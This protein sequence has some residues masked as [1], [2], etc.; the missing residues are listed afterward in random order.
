MRTPE[1]VESIER[2]LSNMSIDYKLIDA[3]RYSKETFN[4]SVFIDKK[5][6]FGRNGRA[7]TNGE[8]GCFLSHKKIWE[9]VFLSC[10]AGV[11]FE[12]DA[13]VDKR[14]VG[15]LAQLECSKLDYDVILL[16]HSKKD[17]RSRKLYHFLEPLKNHIKLGDYSVGR[18]FKTW[19]SGAVGYVVTPQGAEKL[20]NSSIEIK[21]VLDDW[22]LFEQ[23][24]A[25]V[26]E[27]RPLL[28]WED[29]INMKSSLENDRKTPARKKIFF[30]ARI[31]RG[32][33]RNAISKLG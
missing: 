29:F 2:Q 31:L 3:V 15:F 28:V 12:D 22:P 21:S 32:L 25:I 27:V 8:V 6:V 9:Q 13:I 24:G 5:I 14:L 26:K 20:L 19:P 7:L 4:D 1:R 16:G 30:L 18:G 33:V 23:Q 10:N 17:H 11:V